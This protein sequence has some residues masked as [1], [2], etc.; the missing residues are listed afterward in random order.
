MV[1]KLST[2]VMKVDLLQISKKIKKVLIY[3]WKQLLSLAILEK[4]NLVWMLLLVNFMFMIIKVMILILKTQ[5]IM[6]VACKLVDQNYKIC[7]KDLLI[8]TQWFLL[9][10]HLIKMILKT[11]LK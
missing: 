11:T 2:L 3:S 10:T 1:K 8:T 5:P 4:F 7:T 9:K 6:T